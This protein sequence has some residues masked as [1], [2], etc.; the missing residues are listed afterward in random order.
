MQPCSFRHENAVPDDASGHQPPSEKYG[1][2][3]WKTTATA[4][5]YIENNWL[6]KLTYLR[7]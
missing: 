3:V 6:A 4:V 2:Y 5:S 1:G 7:N